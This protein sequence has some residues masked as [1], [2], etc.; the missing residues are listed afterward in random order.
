MQ[1]KN[2]IS[3]QE[4]LPFEKFFGKGIIKTKDN[5]YIKII[6]V[7]PINYNLKSNLEKERNTKFI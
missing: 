1:N 6:K 7:V 4:W 2:C 3:L 5:E